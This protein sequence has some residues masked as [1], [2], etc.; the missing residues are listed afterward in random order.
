MIGAGLSRKVKGGV[1][2]LLTHENL[3]AYD[4]FVGIVLRFFVFN[5]FQLLKLDQKLLSRPLPADDE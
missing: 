1:V 3:G 2:E 4:G 5:R